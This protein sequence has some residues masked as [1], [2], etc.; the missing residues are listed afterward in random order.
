MSQR[1]PIIAP[2]QRPPLPS[3][4]HSLIDG[5]GDQGKSAKESAVLLPSAP[6]RPEPSNIS[7]EPEIDHSK[8]VA[9]LPIG[10]KIDDRYE[11]SGVLGVGGFATV[12]RAHHLMI[13][14]DV[15]LKVMDLQ[16]G[17]DPSYTQRFFREAK[18]AAKI[19]HN[20]VV[21]IYDFGFVAETG[22]P[23]IAMEMLHGHDLGRELSKNGPL[24]PNRIYILFR[25]ILAALGQGHRLGI[26]HKDLKP[27]NLYLTDPG[28]TRE[29]MKVLDFGVARLDSAEIS[30]LTSAGQLLGTPRYLAPEY[31]KAQRVSP[32][33][34]VY[35]M[36]LI[37]SEALTGVPAVAGDPFH[38][39]MLH[40]SGQLQITDFLREGP[41]GEVFKRAT[42]LDPEERYAN[43]DDFG[44]AL[45]GL[46]SF[47][48]SKTP[49][50]GG[51][52]QLSPEWRPSS[53]IINANF[54]DM[55]PE[56]S[57][58][59][60]PST[61]ISPYK[62]SKS[63]L[64]ILIALP[65]ALI[66][67]IFSAVHFFSEKPGSTEPVAVVA[68]EAKK[69]EFQFDSEPQ[70]A[71]IKLKGGTFSICT[72]PCTHAFTSNDLPTTL[73]F[74]L[75]NY[76]DNELEISELLHSRENGRTFLELTQIPMDAPKLTFTI[77]YEPKNARVAEVGSLDAICTNSPCDYI[78]DPTRKSV[79]LTIS[80]PDH[81]QQ[82]VDLDAETHAE[83]A[84]IA[85]ELK[86]VVKP[87]PVARPTRKP[88]T[89]TTTTKTPP[90]DSPVKEP[91]TT[92]TKKPTFD[93]L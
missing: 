20:N 84:L 58:P 64:F 76:K 2:N 47:F 22:Q 70:G 38:A 23:Y 32:A 18:I 39:M 81:I 4:K 82:N 21:S 1:L 53:K 8:S 37:F 15:A 72:T 9:T 41:V 44:Q 52:P 7:A 5:L 45:D 17:V 12:Y 42:A 68:Q 55:V 57:V 11:I 89:T 50:T 25:P 49:L 19:H 40:C 35:Q 92:P 59:S 3:G 65:I 63:K 28:T 34:D 10:M 71:D 48:E 87:N 27:E 66:V 46:A 14:R 6:K 67:L 78:F 54:S 62:S 24:S 85:I 73:V 30:K 43:C 13:D 60:G 77:N 31:I 75:E 16:K 33:I 56:V 86:K 51:V 69:L 80:A 74:S 93:L 90:A 29:Q 88:S 91:P 26:V 83:S 79:R 36:A 61:M